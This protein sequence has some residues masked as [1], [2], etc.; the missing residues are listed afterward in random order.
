MSYTQIIFDI[1]EYYPS[2]FDFSGYS[3]EII[4]DETKF[5]GIIFYE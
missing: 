5:N 4:S 2:N 1:A 3:F